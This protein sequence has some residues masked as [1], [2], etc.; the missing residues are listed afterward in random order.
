MTRGTQERL[1]VRGSVVLLWFGKSVADGP[2]ILRQAGASADEALEAPAPRGAADP[3]LFARWLDAEHVLDKV[4]QLPPAMRGLD[5]IDSLAP[6]EALALELV[7]VSASRHPPALLR[8]A[9]ELDALCD[10]LIGGHQGF[11]VDNVSTAC[12]SFDRRRSLVE[13]RPAFERWIQVHA[14][15]EN[16]ARSAHTHGLARFARPDLECSVAPGAP[17]GVFSNFLTGLAQTIVESALQPAPGELF[18]TPDGRFRIEVVSRRSGSREYNRENGILRL[19]LRAAEDQPDVFGQG[20][21][22]GIRGEYFYGPT[23]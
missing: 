11:L 17:L 19:E 4:R 3:S 9:Q 18:V 5:D 15:A 10:R 8:E 16:G 13:S 12:M 6:R 20:S 2:T 22:G 14:I 23:N 21:A 7:S 1:T